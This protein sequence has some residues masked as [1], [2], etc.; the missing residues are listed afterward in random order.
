M[1]SDFLW[2]RP[3]GRP[4]GCGPPR[5]GRIT[6]RACLRRRSGRRCHSSSAS[7]DTARCIPARPPS[8]GFD[9][10][11]APRG[12][13]GRFSAAHVSSRHRQGAEPSGLIRRRALRDFPPGLVPQLRGKRGILSPC[14]PSSCRKPTGSVPLSLRP[15]F[16]VSAGLGL[17][18][19]AP[20]GRWSSSGRP[21]VVLRIGMAV[22]TAAY[23][24]LWFLA[25]SRGA[26]AGWPALG[27]FSIVVLAWS[28]LSVA[29]TALVAEMYA[30]GGN[31]GEGL[32]LFNAVTALA[33]R[34]RSCR[35]RLGSR[36]PRL[37]GG[38]RGGAGRNRH[39]PGLAFR[40][41]PCERREEEV[42][43]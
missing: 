12:V 8:T 18:L 32:G 3:G 38:P 4:A 20:A 28:A 23:A 36:G 41:T 27:L 9:P 10:R 2:R 43:S 1:A 6:R 30:R 13:A 7:G 15:S 21:R 5:A 22:R 40:G 26:Q 29:S 19:Y 16:A 33:R 37:R 24:L 25:L 11:P 42:L 31:E 34:G 35:R 39:R 17:F 14:I